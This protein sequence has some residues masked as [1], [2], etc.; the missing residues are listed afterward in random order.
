MSEKAVTGVR[1]K[2]KLS[3]EKACGKAILFRLWESETKGREPRLY[4]VKGD[5]YCSKFICAE[6][7]FQL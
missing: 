5:Y 6:T 4:S 7:I 3:Y 2:L 1:E